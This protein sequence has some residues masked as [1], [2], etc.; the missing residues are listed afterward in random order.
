MFQNSDRKSVPV[1]RT[2]N[3]DVSGASPRHYGA[4]VAM[5]LYN[6]GLGIPVIQMNRMR[7]SPQRG[8]AGARGVF[9]KTR[10]Y[11]LKC[12][13]T[14]NFSFTDPPHTKPFRRPQ[15]SYLKDSGEI[16]PV[17]FLNTMIFLGIAPLRA[18]RLREFH[19]C[20]LVAN[21]QRVLR[22]HR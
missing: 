11:S 14:L 10:N 5:E 1:Q 7:P 22:H 8:R 16:I 6:Q 12:D 18:K 17:L 20:T 2:K 15:L 13:Y 4:P 3:A 21:P 9:N 19:P